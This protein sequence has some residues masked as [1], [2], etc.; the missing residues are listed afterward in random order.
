MIRLDYSGQYACNL[1]AVLLHI[2]WSPQATMV[3]RAQR[4]K[5]THNS[6]TYVVDKIP[7]CSVYGSEEEFHVNKRKKRGDLPPTARGEIDR[8]RTVESKHPAPDELSFV[9]WLLNY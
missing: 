7:F 8:I 5:D 4:P 9:L 2:G 1:S 3:R 6:S